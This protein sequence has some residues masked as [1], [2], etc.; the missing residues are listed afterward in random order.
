MAKPVQLFVTCLVDLLYP[1]VGE[2]AVAALRAAGFE[3]SVPD[4]Q[5]CCGQPLYNN[6]MLAEAAAVARTNIAA[7][8]GDDPIVVP[9][10]SCAWTLKKAYPELV[11]EDATRQFA[12]RVV[13]L[14]ELVGAN[15]LPPLALPSPATI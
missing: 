11:P 6:G 12:G 8:R 1:G 9:S 7:L 3:P 10:G 2:S 5:T 15:T 13:E 14:T 4:D